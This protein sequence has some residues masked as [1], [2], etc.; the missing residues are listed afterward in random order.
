MHPFFSVTI[1]EVQRLTDIQARELIARLCGAELR[2]SGISQAAVTW[3]G[4]ERQAPPIREASDDAILKWCDRSPSDRCLFA[5]EVCGPFEKSE[6]PESEDRIVVS[7]SELAKQIFARS[8]DKSAVIKI[9]LGNFVPT[10]WS[11]SRAEIIRRR[12]P[13][14]DELNPEKDKFLCEVISQ[15]KE[16]FEK[17]IA[18]EEKQEAE[19]ERERTNRFE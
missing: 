18:S 17:I 15:E 9:Y 1:E 6:S 3:G 4:D 12:L 14:I 19:R 2:K 7:L 8:T 13:L 5:A 11:G 10:S 16:K